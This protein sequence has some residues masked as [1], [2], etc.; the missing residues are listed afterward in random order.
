MRT[1]FLFFL[2]FFCIT[3]PALAWLGRVV[4]VS[5]GDTISVEPVGGG[6]RVKVR[7]HGIDC[8]ERRPAY[9]EAARFF[10]N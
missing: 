6:A 5:D 3:E 8:P 9:G 7:L 1:I 2:I 4:S 10:V